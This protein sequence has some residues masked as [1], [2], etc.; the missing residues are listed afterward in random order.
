[1][2]KFILSC[3]RSKAAY[4]HAKKT[5]PISSHLEWIEQAWL[6]KDL[7]NWKV[8]VFSR[9]S[10]RV[11]Q[12]GQESAILHA[13]INN[14]FFFPTHGTNHTIKKLTHRSIQ[15]LYFWLQLFI[16]LVSRI[17][18]Q[19]LRLFRHV[20]LLSRCNFLSSYIVFWLS[21]KTV[22]SRMAVP[23]WPI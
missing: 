20:P 13:Q 6:T 12:S 8:T 16:F 23:K 19:N 17:V 14:Q 22:K 11:I 5:R 21:A 18:L 2:A 4:K 9:V 10:Q 1:M 15:R 7:L 3:L